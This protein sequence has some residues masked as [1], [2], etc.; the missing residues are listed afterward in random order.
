MASTSGGGHDEKRTNSWRKRIFEKYREGK[1]YSKDVWSESGLR[2]RI[3]GG[4]GIPGALT[5]VRPCFDQVLSSASH[6]KSTDKHL[7]C[8]WLETAW[9]LYV[10]S[11]RRSIYAAHSCL[12]YAIGMTIVS[13][14]CTAYSFRALFFS[15]RVFLQN[16]EC[17]YLRIS[18]CI[19]PEVQEPAAP[20][21]DVNW[22][23]IIILIML[24]WRVEHCVAV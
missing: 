5:W 24:T 15:W 8:T 3:K 11:L 2:M 9:L 17:C 12:I 18:R 22:A 19:F 6:H 1:G 10:F 21:A 4:S 7:T 14:L 23:R 20:L 16:C 13:H